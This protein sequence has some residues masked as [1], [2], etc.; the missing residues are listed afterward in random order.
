MP[1]SEA[2]LVLNLTGAS[3]PNCPPVHGGNLEAECRAAGVDPAGVLDFSA[4]VNALGPPQC[5]D[6]VLGEAAQGVVRT[7]ARYADP[8][9]TAAR[10]ALAHKHGVE[11]DSV[12]VGNGL[13]E[14]LYLALRVLRPERTLVLGPTYSD[15]VRA[16]VLAGS[17]VDVAIAAAARNFRHDL[18]AMRDTSGYDFV[19]LANPNNPTGTFVRPHMILEWAAEN[20]QTFFLVNE[21]YADFVDDDRGSLVGIRCRNIVVLKSMS[22]FFAVPGLRLGMLWADPEVARIVGERQEPWSVNAIAQRL[23]CRLYDE[24]GYIATTRR[25][26]RE[27]RSYLTRNLTELGFRV[28]D[29]PANFLLLR[30]ETRELDSAALKRRLLQRRILVRDCS[31]IQG[32]DSRFV[33]VTVRLRHENERLLQ[34]MQAALHENG[35]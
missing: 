3:S 13:T 5:V 34:A 17:K 18:M 26:M 10:T 27:G 29:C 31:N 15:H 21:A 4:N 20:P 22:K 11:P 1:V 33:R 19:M 23:A 24:A 2:R 7:A 30:I 14:L 12:L 6:A 35:S 32:L 9:S 25:V 16:A 28:Y 8:H